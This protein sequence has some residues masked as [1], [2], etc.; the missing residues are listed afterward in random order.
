M[1]LRSPLLSLAVACAVVWVISTKL[2]FAGGGEI[3]TSPEATIVHHE[4]SVFRADPEYAEKPYSAEAQKDIYG[5]KTAVKTPRPM[6]EFGRKQYQ[7]G[8]F[9]PGIDLIGSKNLL[10]PA[11]TAYG[12]WR[13]AVAYNDSGALEQGILATRLNLDLD[14][15]LTGT[16]R[17]HAFMRPLDRGGQFSRF[18]FSADDDDRSEL[19]FDLNLDTLFFEG[20]L[21]ALAT[22][23]TG[24]ESH[25]DLPFAV[26]LMPLLFQNG[27]WLEDAFNGIAFSIPARNSPVLDISNM[28]FTFF[29]GFDRVTT[30]AVLDNDGALAD[31][32][33]DVYGAAA[34]IEA[35][36]GYFELGYGYTD[37]EGSKDDQSYHNLT[38]SH[39]RRFSDILSNSVRLIWN[40]GQDRDG[41]AQQTADGYIILLENS[42]ITSRP[43][44]LVPY[45]NFWAGFDR[46]Q[47]LA[48]DGGAG[49]ILKNTGINF[50]T[51]GLTGFPKLDDT[52]R[53]TWGGALGVSY[54]FSLDRQLIGEL[55]AVQTMG[56]AS[57][58][59]AL[60]DQYAV[61]VRYQQPLNEK[62][63]IRGDVM[64]G[65][66]EDTDDLFGIRLEFRRKF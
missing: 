19:E 24:E 29:A 5:G 60:G 63:I 46:P 59:P 61:G 54:L 12:D 18:E 57:G 47:S 64:H 25:F 31:H 44:T 62:W 36:R 3:E 53:D 17:I 48:R 38:I 66:L 20:E 23:F 58:R 40:I 7:T 49:G 28:D 30:G 37:A 35:L 13:S 33:A 42:L 11:F 26:G 4:E 45:G 52:G 8:P 16:E 39:T 50:E 43:L 6:F 15:K 10:F 14:L 32:S 51:D 27:V 1:V 55:A 41:G 34:F 21:G 9:D 2:V 65:W 22:G 56:G